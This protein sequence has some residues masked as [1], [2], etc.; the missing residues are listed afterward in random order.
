[1]QERNPGIGI[2]LAVLVATWLAWW[3]TPTTML[4]NISERK[5]LE[6]LIPSEFGEWDELTQTSSQIVDPEQQQAI[7]RIYSQTL[8]R[9]YIN[10][11]GYR[12]MLSI[13]YGDDQRDAVEIH[14]PEVCYPA[15]GFQVTSNQ[16]G[17][18]NTGKGVIKVQ[19]LLTHL[20]SR[21]EPVTYWTTVGDKVVKGRV[22]K[23]L[24]E[25]EYGV[26]GFIPDGM[27]FRVSSIDGQSDRAF[28]L[29]QAF[30]SDLIDSLDQ[31][32]RLRLSG[33]G[34]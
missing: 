34:S 3:L 16:A 31:E 18:L 29:Q 1:M 27:L 12:V 11:D 6:Q 2:L 8:N 26:K 10:Q 15:Q 9:T 5:D 23:K 25:M 14:Y 28:D 32:S 19:R 4:S 21:H 17:M 7:D 24:A 30:V 22:A 33:L 20:G 13:A